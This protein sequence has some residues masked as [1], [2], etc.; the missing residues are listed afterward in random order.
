[1]VGRDDA[2]WGQRPVAWLVAAGDLQPG[3]SELTE[4]CRERLPA[5]AVPDAFRWCDALPRTDLGK[6]SR[7][8]V[9]ELEASLSK[10][11]CE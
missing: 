10:R 8:R 1:M 7:A 3:S 9:R 5:F 4:W 11:G 2:Q 6:P